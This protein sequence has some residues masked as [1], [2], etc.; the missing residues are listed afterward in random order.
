M[1]TLLLER[2]AKVN[3]PPSEKFTSALQAA[4]HMGNTQYI[5]PLLD[6]GADI[7]A[8]DPR[9]GTA[10]TAAAELRNTA[11]LKK[12]LARGADPHL[13][14]GTYGLVGFLHPAS[15]AMR[16]SITLP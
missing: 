5:D 12:L 14:G 4:I 13:G 16:T 10:L 15:H 6:S 1:V 9:F 2:G 7:N 8:H 11:H 3:L